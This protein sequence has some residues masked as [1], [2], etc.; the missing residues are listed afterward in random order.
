[1]YQMAAITHF[2]AWILLGAFVS[3]QG[4]EILLKRETGVCGAYAAV[5]Y[6]PAND[7]KSLEVFRMKLI[8][9]PPILHKS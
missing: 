9:G 2:F 3:L 1:M 7:L 5:R 8:R 4:S 6:E